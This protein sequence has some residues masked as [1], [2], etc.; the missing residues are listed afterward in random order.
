[1]AVRKKIGGKMSEPPKDIFTEDGSN[2][3]GFM[4]ARW[5]DG[6]VA[7]LPTLTLAA[8]RSQL[9]A[10][11]DGGKKE[12]ASAASAAPAAFFRDKDSAFGNIK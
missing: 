11:D 7:E 3:G 12:R 4:K 6:R 10:G 8:R 1:M 2:P 9:A 5:K